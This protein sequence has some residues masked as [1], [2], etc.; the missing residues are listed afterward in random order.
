MRNLFPLT[1]HQQEF[2]RKG[3][4]VMPLLS[5]DEISFVLS[6][7]QLMRPDDNFNPNRL[8]DKP[9]YH[10]T[11]SDQNIEYKLTAKKLIV[12]ILAPHIKKIFDNYKL[13]DANFI[14]KL[15]GKGR[16]PAHHDWTFVADPENYT[17]LTIWCPL[18]DTNQSNGTLQVVEGSHKIVPDISTSTVDFYCKNFQAAIVDK[19]SKYISLKAGECVIFD[20]S[21][22]HCSNDNR[23]AQ[24]RYVMQAIVLPA[25]IDPVFYYFDRQIP[26]KGF[27]IFQIEPN[28]F[29]FQD[30]N[31]RPINSKSLGFIENK[32]KL[33]TER[34]FLEKMLEKSRK[35]LGIFDYEVEPLTPE[36]LVEKL[37]KRTSYPKFPISTNME[38]YQKQ[39]ISHYKKA[40]IIK[41]NQAVVH[42]RL[43]ELYDT[44]GNLEEA[45]AAYRCAIALNPYLVQVYLKLGQALERQG[46]WQDKQEAIV[47]YRRAMELES[48]VATSNSSCQTSE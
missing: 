1:E 24:P 31:K 16:F 2:E 19:Y 45:I 18:V 21:L 6:E 7:L 39:L 11:N 22:L 27:E 40:L 12:H 46:R 9:S 48:N 20:Q 47:C 14:I 17:S 37:G 33:I 28:F 26:E 25:E 3:Y 8:P 38:T 13:I 44:Q 36:I 10:L 32:N 43:G 4:L 35:S 30:F 41:P 5:V 42:S 29:V 15:P 34:E 23:T